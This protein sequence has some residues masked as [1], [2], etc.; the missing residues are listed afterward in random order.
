MAGTRAVLIV[1]S[2]ANIGIVTHNPPSFSTESTLV[3]S[4]RSWADEE[5]G[6]LSS[7]IIVSPNVT[8]LTILNA[9]RI[10]G[11]CSEVTGEARPDISHPLASREMHCIYNLTKSRVIPYR[12]EQRGSEDAC[13]YS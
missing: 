12:L 7:V 10:V 11:K 9:P 2:P 4:E 8:S 3:V 6:A 1:P 5:V 13:V